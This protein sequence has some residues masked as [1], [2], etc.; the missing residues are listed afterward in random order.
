MTVMEFAKKILELTGSSS[1]IHYLPLP[2]DDPKVRQPDI[3]K[4]RDVLGWEPRIA[5][6]E[7]L[8]KTIDYFQPR[9]TR[10][11]QA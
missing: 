11:S 10:G 3:S 1:P 5:L 4:A 7:G 8:T 9:L 2:E 6:N